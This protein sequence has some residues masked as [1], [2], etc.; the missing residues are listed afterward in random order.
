MSYHS[1]QKLLGMASKYST[2]FGS[3]LNNSPLNANKFKN[4]VSTS[5][6]KTIVKKHF[7]SVDSHQGQENP[8]D[9]YQKQDYLDLLLSKAKT[10]TKTS[11]FHLNDNVVLVF[12]SME[13]F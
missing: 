1:N 13:V 9:M 10:V 5:K 7:E 12:R 11:Y 8:N 6:S 3:T 2:Q 4:M